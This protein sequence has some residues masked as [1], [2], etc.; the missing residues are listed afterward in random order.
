M[1]RCKT[2]DEF[3]DNADPT[4]KSL[5]IK[6][7]EILMSTVLNESIKWGVPVYTLE[8]KK[9]TFP[10]NNSWPVKQSTKPDAKIDPD[11]I[12]RP[13]QTRCQR[14]YQS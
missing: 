14:H 5:I 13:K 4:W 2:V 9:Y 1:K 11:F 7:R 3:I 10:I 8:G 12:K 6:L